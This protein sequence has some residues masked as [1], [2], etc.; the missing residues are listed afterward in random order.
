MKIIMIKKATVFLMAILII[1]ITATGAWALSYTAG[2]DPSGTAMRLYTEGSTKYLRFYTDNNVV[3]PSG[4]AVVGGWQSISGI[5]TLTATGDA[6]VY[7]LSG[8]TSN[9][10]LTNSSGVTTYLTALATAMTIR[11]DTNTISWSDVTNMNVTA[12]GLATGSAVLNDF[13]SASTY[14]FTSF[15]FEENVSESSWLSGGGTLNLRY[16]STLSSFSAAPE[17]AEWMLMFI[18]LGMLGF[19]LQRRGYLNFDLSPQSVA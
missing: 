6:N 18:G 14:A 3:A 19:Y 4:D 16:S 10:Q 15:T 12:A 9:I 13:A 8:A 17:P 11:F 1:A 7:N 5:Y 2:N